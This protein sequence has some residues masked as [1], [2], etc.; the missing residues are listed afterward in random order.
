MASF[1]Y[2]ENDG[3]GD[4]YACIDDASPG[5]SPL[6]HPS[7]WRKL[8][9]PAIF[10]RFLVDSSCAALLMGDGQLDKR[11]MLEDQ[12]DEELAKLVRRHATPPDGP[13][14]KVATR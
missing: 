11:R 5:E 10:E 13:R 3:V 9:I 8:E 1:A 7:K 4:W 12:A 6:T 2:F 14:P